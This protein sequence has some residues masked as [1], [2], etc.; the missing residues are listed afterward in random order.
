MDKKPPAGPT[1]T[2]RNLLVGVAAAAWS[3]QAGPAIIFGAVR[4]SGG[5]ADPGGERFDGRTHVAGAAR[6]P[7][8]GGCRRARNRHR[9]CL[10]DLPA[11]RDFHETTYPEMKK[12]Y[13]DTGKVRFIFRE[14][15]LDPLA[16]AG[17]MLARCAGKDKYFP[18]IETLFAQQRDWVV[19]KPLGALVR[20]RPA[21]RL[22]PAEL[23]RMSGESSRCST[24]SRRSPAR[25]V[26]VQRQ[27]T[28]TFFINGKL[29]RGSLTMEELDK[30][31]APYLKG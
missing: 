13:I 30:Q 2:R 8:H 18:L 29:V 28:P 24:A 23:R 10:D 14:F 15:P 19:Q 25:R 4:R 5:A 22:Y 1:L 7:G 11:L 31:I 3:P 6:R 17:S 16:A 20:Y 9:I 27:S 21:G 26:E 12:K